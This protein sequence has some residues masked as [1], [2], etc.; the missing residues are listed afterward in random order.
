MHTPARAPAHV[1]AHGSDFLV[2]TCTQARTHALTH[3]HILMS[4]SFMCVHTHTHTTHVSLSF[5]FIYAQT[6]RTHSRTY[7]R[8]HVHTN[9]FLISY[10]RTRT[11][12]HTHTHTHK[13]ILMA[14]LSKQVCNIPFSWSLIFDR[15]GT[16]PHGH[17]IPQTNFRGDLHSGTL[18]IHID[19][20]LFARVRLCACIYM[21]MFACVYAYEKH[22][23]SHINACT[24][25]VIACAGTPPSH[26][27][28]RK[29]HPQAEQNPMGY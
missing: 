10:E 28:P 6:T 8:T 5:S 18:C 20:F 9:D 4:S 1:Y 24:H 23:H 13:R 25:I 29:I 21:H 3:I 14:L 15:D 16:H 7:A 12:T 2:H 17:G 19:T 26:F 27:A 22:L 11:H